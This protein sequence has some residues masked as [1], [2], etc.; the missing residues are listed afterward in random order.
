MALLTPTQ[1]RTLDPYTE[2]RWS[3]NVNRLTRLVTGGN[4]IIVQP[5]TSFRLTISDA[6]TVVVHPGLFV[7]DDC[8]VHISADYTLDF[9][10]S[11]GNLY[12]DD[13]GGMDQEGYYFIL[14]QYAYTRSL[15]PT[16][17]FYRIL[18]SLSAYNLYSSSYIYLG[19]IRVVNNAGS[20]EIDTT[21]NPYYSH[22]TYPTTITRST[23]SSPLYVDGGDM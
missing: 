8:L 17:A 23:M 21:L 4:N 3:S 18:K 7:K 20:Y 12:I 22:P 10:D 1:T 11:T 2:E 13:T 15:P 14:I 19:N 5:E 16:K 9:S 6:S